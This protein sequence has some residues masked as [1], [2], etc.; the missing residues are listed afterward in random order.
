M[1]S[2]KQLMKEGLIDDLLGDFDDVGSDTKSIQK[3]S[4]SIYTGK[5]HK[6]R[7]VKGKKPTDFFD[8]ITSEK[9]LKSLFISKLGTKNI[10]LK[11]IITLFAVYNMGLRDNITINLPVSEISTVREYDRTIIDGWTGKQSSNDFALLKADIKKNGMK[12]YGIVDMTRKSGGDIDV[13]L[14]EGNH[15]L[16]IAK[17]LKLKTMPIRFYYKK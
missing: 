10:T 13:I 7:S 15:R 8:Y 4:G 1:K 14:G 12:N 11:G 16:A 5:K 6:P 17:E 3:T 2:F 9:E